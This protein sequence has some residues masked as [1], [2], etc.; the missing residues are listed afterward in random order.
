[1]ILTFCFLHN[2]TQRKTCFAWG[3]EAVSIHNFHIYCTVWRKIRNE[4]LHVLLIA[5]AL[6]SFILIRLDEGLNYHGSKW[7]DIYVCTLKPCA[8]YKCSIFTF[9][10]SYE[11]KLKS[12]QLFITT[13]IVLLAHNRSHSP[14]RH[15]KGTLPI[16][17][18]LKSSTFLLIPACIGHI[19]RHGA[20]KF[21]NHCKW[22]L[23]IINFSI[24]Y[25]L[26]SDIII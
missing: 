16:C 10:D 6:S 20:E 9:L 26:L 22:E 7:N 24:K 15:T 21:I 23:H 19:H 11:S 12:F 3:R 25:D 8:L 14:L 1:V 17:T 2:K 18:S 13:Y 4:S 5:W